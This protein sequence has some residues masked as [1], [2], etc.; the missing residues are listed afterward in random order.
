MKRSFKVLL[1]ATLGLG[2]TTAQAAPPDGWTQNT[3]NAVNIALQSDY[4]NTSNDHD[5]WVNPAMINKYAGKA[6]V[7]D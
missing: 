1:G 6:Y 5:I 3:E 7:D 2:V 4:T